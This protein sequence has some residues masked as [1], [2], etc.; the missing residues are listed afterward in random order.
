MS[1]DIPDAAAGA[2]SAAIL[3]WRGMQTRADLEQLVCVPQTC[4]EIAGAADCYVEDLVR[5]RATPPALASS[6]SR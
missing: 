2:G 5:R 1:Q 4:D 6:S 3:D